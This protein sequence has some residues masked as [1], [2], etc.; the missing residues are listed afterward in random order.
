MQRSQDQGALMQSWAARR[1]HSNN[2]RSA[3]RI[4]CLQHK[5][6]EVAD[7]DITALDLRV[8]FQP[9]AC[10]A[11]QPLCLCLHKLA[12]GHASC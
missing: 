11:V 5:A 6:D 4:K 1:T 2:Q 10:V 3:Q 7:A 9:C 8:G 12:T